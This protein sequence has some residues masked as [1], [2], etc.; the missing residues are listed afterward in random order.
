MRVTFVLHLAAGLYRGGLE[1]Q[2]ENT[3]KAL[4]RQGVH[5]R[6]LSPEDRE[7][8][9]DIVHFFGTYPGFPMVGHACRTRRMPYVCTPVLLVHEQG[10]KLRMR[11]WRKRYLQASFPKDQMQLYRHAN[12]LF[13]LTSAE[14]RNLDDYF[15][16]GLAPKV[17]IPI[18]IDQRFAH[19][20]AQVF[21]ERFGISVPFVLQTGRLE[22]RKNQIGVIRAMKGLGIPLVLIGI[23]EDA[24]YREACLAEGKGFVYHLGKLDLDDP[25]LS[26]AYAAAKVFAMP[27]GSEVLSASAL[28]AAVAGLPSILG[29]SWGAQE[30]LGEDARYVR[31]SDIPGIRAGIEHFWDKPGDR[32]ARSAKYGPVFNWDNVARQIIAE[33]EKVLSEVRAC[34]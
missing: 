14:E 2:G 11:A 8:E 21:R 9:S 1:L 27:S 31:P 25:A 15:G 12:R 19:G 26:G 33:Y 18:G 30:Y 10:R 29:D 23:A 28:E 4:E 6:L 5:V 17:R 32:L 20:D 3:R 16:A 13:T 7:L 34:A 22:G 24:A